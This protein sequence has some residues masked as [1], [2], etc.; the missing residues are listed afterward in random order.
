MKSNKV[1]E[2]TEADVNAAIRIYIKDKLKEKEISGK[3]TYYTSVRGD[4]DRGNAQEYVKSV[5]VEI[6][7]L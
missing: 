3:I 2:L 4:Y 6:N 5:I 1:I 7:E